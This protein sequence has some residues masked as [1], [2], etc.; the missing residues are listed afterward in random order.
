MAKRASAVME[1]KQNIKREMSKYTLY[2]NNL[3][4]VTVNILQLVLEL[5]YPIGYIKNI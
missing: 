2:S 1:D 4:N 5:I 3:V